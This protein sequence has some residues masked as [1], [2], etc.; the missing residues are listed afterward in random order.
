MKALASLLPFVLVVVVF[1][2]LTLP[3]RRQRRRMQALIDQLKIGDE[4]MMQSG[5]YGRIDDLADQE[6][7]VEIA[8]G[9]LT[10]WTKGAVAAVVS[11]ST[12]TEASESMHDPAQGSSEQTT[13]P[14]SKVSA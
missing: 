8:P 10:R 4:V 6:V 2:V 7:V 11:S 5:Q 12:P 13:G 1:F 14:D 9:V 3:V